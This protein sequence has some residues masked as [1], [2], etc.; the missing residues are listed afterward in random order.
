[1]CPSNDIQSKQLLGTENG[2]FKLFKKFSKRQKFMNK[3]LL[4]R[5]GY[6]CF[7]LKNANQYEKILTFNPHHAKYI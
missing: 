6:C 7:L 2:L 3:L 5:N 4:L 1:M